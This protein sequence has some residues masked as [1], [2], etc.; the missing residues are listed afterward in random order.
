M[1]NPNDPDLTPS[2]IPAQMPEGFAAFFQAESI[3]REIV[4]MQKDVKDLAEA[5]RD[6]AGTFEGS[7]R[8]S[9]QMQQK[10]LGLLSRTQDAQVRLEASM[11]RIEAA[12]K[13]LPDEVRGVVEPYLL[14]AELLGVTRECLLI[15]R[16][17]AGRGQ[18]GTVAEGQISPMTEVLRLTRKAQGLDPETGKERDVV[19]RAWELLKKSAI[20]AIWAAIALA[21]LLYLAKLIQPK[22]FVVQVP[23]LQDKSQQQ[24]TGNEPK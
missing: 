9:H 8:L 24:G 20:N 14:S 16:V 2:R 7:D 10:V 11:V 13:S 23:V 21:L 17:L 18:D 15:L 1:S 12:L 3:R 5:Y 4:Q 22:A 6:M 19:G